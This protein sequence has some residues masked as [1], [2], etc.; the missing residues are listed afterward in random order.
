MEW[1]MEKRKSYKEERKDKC[2]QGYKRGRTEKR[3]E[4]LDLVLAKTDREH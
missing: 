2:K 1:K 3:K 4:G